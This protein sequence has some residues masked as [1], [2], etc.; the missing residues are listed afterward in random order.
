MSS[1]PDRQFFVHAPHTAIGV[2]SAVWRPTTASPTPE[3]DV[4]PRLCLASGC[5]SYQSDQS[6]SALGAFVEQHYDLACEKAFARSRRDLPGLEH[7]EECRCLMLFAQRLAIEGPQLEQLREYVA[8]GGSVV[9]VIPPGSTFLNWPGWEADV[10]GIQSTGRA[11]GSPGAAIE[12]APYAEGHSVLRDVGRLRHAGCVTT[13]PD[14]DRHTTA[15]LSARIEKRLE[16]VAWV[17]THGETR[18]FFTTLGQP[19]DFQQPA[20]LQLLANAVLWA[21]GAPESSSRI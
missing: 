11:Y 16:P 18:S 17:R 21:I 3:T 8:G 5:P 13:L 2:T 4:R 15:L 19:I 6:L 10:L 20:F 9:A 1:L 14:L 7:L 12:T